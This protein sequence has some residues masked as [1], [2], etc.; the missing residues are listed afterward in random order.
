ML[1]RVA[2]DT[3]TGAH[4]VLV[5]GSVA[6]GEAEL[7]SDIDLVVIAARD[8]DGRRPSYRPCPDDIFEKLVREFGVDRHTASKC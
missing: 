3:V 5:F 1:K 4:A 2:A 8:W 7:D 6:R